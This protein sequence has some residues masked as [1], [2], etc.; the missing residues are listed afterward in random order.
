MSG[1]WNGEASLAESTAGGGRVAFFIA[2]PAY[3][4]GRMKT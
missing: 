3:K 4:E 1:I 2:W